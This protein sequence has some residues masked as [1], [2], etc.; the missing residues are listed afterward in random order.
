MLPYRVLD[1]SCL[2]QT[3]VDSKAADIRWQRMAAR[4]QALRSASS[5]ATLLLQLS[6]Q[7]L[8]STESTH[9]LKVK[10]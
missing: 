7:L 4:R 9:L 10:L 2:P 1:H 6:F 8:V 3:Y 5:T